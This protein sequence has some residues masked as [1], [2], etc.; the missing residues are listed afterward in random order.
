MKFDTLIQ[1]DMPISAIWSKSQPE[2]KVQYGGRLF[3]PTGS[4]YELRYVDVIWFVGRF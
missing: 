1:N 3:F 4:S 2:E